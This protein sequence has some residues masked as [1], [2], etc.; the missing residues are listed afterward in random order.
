MSALSDW[1]SFYVIVGSS[2]GGLTGLQFVVAALVADSPSIGAWSSSSPAFATPTI[3]HFG[4]VLVLSALFSMPWTG[5]ALPM[6]VVG[7]G[8]VAGV[9]YALYVAHKARSLREYRPVFED[10]LFHVLLPVA[11]YLTFIVSALETRLHVE[12][13]LFGVAGA[14][15]LLLIV[16]IHNAWDS[17]NY[18]VARRAQEQRHGRH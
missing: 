5:A 15:L 8:G 12:R 6:I 1:E 11:A 7:L 14:A 17:V 9:T 13:A 18:I 10:W 3:V 4:V 16:G 2:A